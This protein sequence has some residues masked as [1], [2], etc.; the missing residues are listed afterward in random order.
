MCMYM[1][2][3]ICVRRVGLI[4]ARHVSGKPVLNE[5]KALKIG[6]YV[7]YDPQNFFACGGP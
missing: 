1:R 2:T 4:N 7:R 3:S 5:T 6:R